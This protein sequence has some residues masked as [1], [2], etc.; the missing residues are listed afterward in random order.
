MRW[1]IHSGADLGRAIA[2]IRRQQDLTQAELA[3]Q[4]G[5][6]RGYLAHL[7]AGRTSASLEHMLRVLRRSGATVTISLEEEEEEE[8]DGQA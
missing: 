6:S 5:L 3:E 4:T 1:N 2:D 7:E 8:E